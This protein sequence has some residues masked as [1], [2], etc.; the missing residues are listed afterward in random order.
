MGRPKGS[1]NEKNDNLRAF[2]I[3]V[4]R[5][6]IAATNQEGLE[7]LICRLMTDPK[8]PAVAAAIASKWV[9]W[10]YGKA[11]ETHEH[12]VQVELNVN[13]AERIIAEYFVLASGRQDQISQGDTGE[14]QEQDKHILPS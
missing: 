8:S 13:D 3:R 7:R 11:T 4:E 10:R 9:E 5:Q 2:A 6:I 12:K 14:A 1:K